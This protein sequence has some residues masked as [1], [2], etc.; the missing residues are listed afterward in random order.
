MTEQV[1]KLSR[2]RIAADVLTTAIGLASVL[3]FL[4]AANDLALIVGACG[5]LLGTSTAVVTY[6]LIL[7]SV[8]QR[9]TAPR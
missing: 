5:L 4:A 1:R 3:L 2:R 8:G 9:Q 6:C 7:R